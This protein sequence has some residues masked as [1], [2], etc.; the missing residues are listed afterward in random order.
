ME[1]GAIIDLDI[2]EGKKPRVKQITKESP[3]TQY[4]TK[5]VR[6]YKGRE[7]VMKTCR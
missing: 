7:K 5:T 4:K 2:T 3:F 1:N 6:M